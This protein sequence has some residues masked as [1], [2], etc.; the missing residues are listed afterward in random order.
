ME[1]KTVPFLSM[2]GV[3][4][5]DDVDAVA[6]V[7]SAVADGSGTFFPLPQEDDFQK[8]FAEHEG[9]RKAIATN[10][11]GTALDCCMMALG[12]QEGDEVI[13]TPL[14]FVC[15]AGTAIARGARIVFAD[16]DPV[17]LNLDP[18][19][20]REKIT[21]R[22]RAI[23]P[24]HFSGLACDIDEFDKIAQEFAI[25]V[26][27]DAAH[28]VGTKYK[29]QPIGGRGTA[30]CYS[31]QS[32]KNM[33]CLG[34]GGAVTSNVP[35]FAEQVRQLKTFGYVYGGSGV[36]VA[37]IGFNYRMNKAQ[38]AVGITQLS[39]I[40]RVIRARQQRM[41][42]LN[43]LL[44]DVP[45]LILPAGHGPEHGS[46]LH[47]V[48]L[49]TDAVEFSTAEFVAR[50]KEKYKVG[51]ARHYPPVWSWEALQ[52]KGY[53]GDGCPVAAKSCEQVFSTPVFPGTTD[54]DLVYVAWAIKQTLV[55]LG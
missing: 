3:Y 5:Q 8:R 10:S 40:D 13:T 50:L 27:Y 49:D 35:E 6:R 51:T 30:A 38:C 11:C 9:A 26:I 36:R 42:R 31:F 44:A 28:A 25:P 43:E 2:G 17:T 54:G 23:I 21:S 29:G 47:V 55:D 7:V 1:I 41:A 20:V 16:V 39:R 24:V 53:N 19:A 12:I 14:T 32:N 22:T 52:E 34:E 4:E 33:T 15:T 48:R 37:S 45:E 18:A 46:H